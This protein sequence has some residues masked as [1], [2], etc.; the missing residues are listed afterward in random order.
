MRTLFLLMFLIA[1]LW[2]SAAEDIA[3]V[4][5][6]TNKIKPV[7]QGA[8]GQVLVQ[9]GVSAYSWQTIGVVGATGAT[10][11]T[12]A[13][14][15]MG[16]TGATGAVGTTGAT[17]ATGV[18][19]ATGAT[20]AVGP[21]GPPPATFPFSAVTTDTNT[22]ANMTVGN[23][24]TISV[25]PGGVIGLM[26]VSHSDY[27]FGTGALMA[28][29]DGISNIAIGDYALYHLAHGNANVGIGQG[30]LGNANGYGCVG[31]VGIGANGGGTI[32]TGDHNTCIGGSSYVSS[33]GDTNETVLGSA[34]TGAGSNTVTL[35]NASVTDVYL[36]SNAG[37]NA[38]ANAF[39]ASGP[40][41]LVVTS[42][43]C[44]PVLTPGSI[45]TT[46]RVT[47]ANGANL[48]I[49]N[50]TG[51][52]D[53]QIMILEVDQDST[54]GGTISFGTGNTTP[55]TAVSPFVFGTSF[56]S[57]TL[58]TGASQYDLIGFYY[59]A[60]TGKWGIISFAPGYR[61]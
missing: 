20:G 59:T 12:G 25:A 5:P 54:G 24:A 8:P 33:G 49:N 50:P 18:T 19:G 42:N 13:T 55:G 61:Q 9:T 21:P 14:G 26:S 38:H 40:G 51:M 30:A 44:T 27:A 4:D 58:S 17:G 53:G 16:A 46:F 15:A 43:A 29:V 35:G 23:G 2:A 52:S 56:T 47:A 36:S 39:I 48:T 31:N 28:I 3:T 45:S 37:A 6:A 57:I 1:S 10:G 22:T 41:V 34:T 60:A 7:L 32:A 11:T